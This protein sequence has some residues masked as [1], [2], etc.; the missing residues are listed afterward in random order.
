[1][2]SFED[3]RKKKLHESYIEESTHND[4][5]AKLAK[6]ANGKIEPVHSVITTD[7]PEIEKHV[8]IL[9][10]SIDNQFL[11]SEK[12]NLK[13]SHN[14]KEKFLSFDVDRHGHYN[15]FLSTDNPM[16]ALTVAQMMAC[17]NGSDNLEKWWELVKDL[18]SVIDAAYK[19]SPASFIDFKEIGKGVG[20]NI[21]KWEDYYDAEVPLEILTRIGVDSTFVRS[22]KY[23]L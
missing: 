11:I 17:F 8:S 3:F 16:K 9:Y 6:L 2:K 18:K 4:D 13:N 10:N 5:A 19:S 23:G 12:I 7:N 21:K 1:M 14:D 22:R 15:F 20:D